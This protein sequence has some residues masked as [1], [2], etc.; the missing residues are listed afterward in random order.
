MIFAPFIRWKNKQTSPS[1]IH[2]QSEQHCLPGC[3][4]RPFRRPGSPVLSSSL[5]V[6]LQPRLPTATNCALRRSVPP[7]AVP[8]S[9]VSLHALPQA[10]PA[11]R[12]FFTRTLPFSFS[13]GTQISLCHSGNSVLRT[14][15]LQNNGIRAGHSLVYRLLPLPTQTPFSRLLPREAQLRRGPAEPGVSAARRGTEVPGPGLGAERPR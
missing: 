4:A 12:Y 13:T 11:R 7:T 3:T 15:L 8:L 9:A 6:L 1:L 5:Q 10:G 2:S 14:R